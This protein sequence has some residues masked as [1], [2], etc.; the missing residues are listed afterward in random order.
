MAGSHNGLRQAADRSGPTT[1]PERELRDK[2]TTGGSDRLGQ[3]AALASRAGLAAGI[4]GY[5]M[6]ED[7]LH[8]VRDLDYDEDRDAAPAGHSK[9]S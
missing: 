4:R 3:R 1:G 5:W 9:R 8:W 6:I 2:P 7:R